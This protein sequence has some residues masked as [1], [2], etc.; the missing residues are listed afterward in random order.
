MS[1]PFQI[2]ISESL[3]ELEKALR[4]ATQASSKERLLSSLLAQEWTGKQQ[5]IAAFAF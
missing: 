1:R 4:H 2:E 5:A 3:E